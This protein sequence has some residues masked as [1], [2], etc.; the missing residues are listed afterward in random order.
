MHDFFQSSAFHTN[1]SSIHFS[2]WK[3]GP[4]TIP[5]IKTH[6]GVILKL[7]QLVPPV[8]LPVTEKCLIEHKAHS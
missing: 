2:P 7:S 1:A 5:V 4:M 3:Q 6:R 8:C